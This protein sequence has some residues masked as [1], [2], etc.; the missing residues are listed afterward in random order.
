VPQV[1]DAAAPSAGPPS[2]QPVDEDRVRDVEVEH[3]DARLAPESPVERLRLPERPREPVEQVALGAVGSRDAIEQHLEHDLVGDEASLAH[4]ALGALAE[5][6]AAREV[7]AEE[8][9]GR[10][11]RQPEARRQARGLRPLPGARRTEQHVH[12]RLGHFWLCFSVHLGPAV[13]MKPS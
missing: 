4:E 1:V 9:S 6:R 8:V 7:L 5:R 11:V 12:A 13:F 2:G 10:D 3:D